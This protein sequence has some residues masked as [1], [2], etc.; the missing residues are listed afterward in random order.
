MTKVT[1]NMCSRDTSCMSREM[2]KMDGRD[3]AKCQKSMLRDIDDIIKFVL[4]DN[5]TKLC[6]V[7][8]PTIEIRSQK[9]GRERMDAV[10]DFCVLVREYQASL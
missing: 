3:S 7:S 1:Y 9:R 8:S 6:I 5:K 10:A 4:N 2:I